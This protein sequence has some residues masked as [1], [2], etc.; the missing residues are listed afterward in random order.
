MCFGGKNVQNI[1]YHTLLMRETYAVINDYVRLAKKG[2][3][4]LEICRLGYVR[5]NQ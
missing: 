5:Y 1:N 2:R 3:E 4:G